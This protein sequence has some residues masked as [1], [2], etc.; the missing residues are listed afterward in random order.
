M[1]AFARAFELKIVDFAPG[2]DARQAWRKRRSSRHLRPEACV[3]GG[4]CARTAGDLCLNFDVSP[5][6]SQLDADALCEAELRAFKLAPQAAADSSQT[7]QEASRHR[8]SHQRPAHAQ[9]NHSSLVELRLFEVR[10]DQ[11]EPRLLDIRRVDRG[12]VGWTTFF[13]KPSISELLRGRRPEARVTFEVRANAMFGA[14]VARDE[15]RF[16]AQSAA[17]GEEAPLL[18]IY[19]QR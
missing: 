7:A 9:F 16:A 2:Q 17:E 6:A 12:F 10:A 13:V 18:V 11:P 14:R 3:E 8:G 4:E 1:S 15:I 19:S 5:L